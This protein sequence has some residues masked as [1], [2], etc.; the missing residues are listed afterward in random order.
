[1]VFC[2][3]KIS[4][5]VMKTKL[6]LQNIEN[7]KPI[8]LTTGLQA[9]AILLREGLEALLIITALAVYL[10]K[11]NLG[12]RVKALWLGAAA[13]IGV[14]LVAGY[15][16]M[17]FLTHETAEFIEGTVM[18][19]AAAL[20]FYV[21]GWLYLRQNPVV[22]KKFLQDQINKV[23][24]TATMLPLVGIAF[25]AV[26]RE[27][28]ETVLFLNALA[29]SAGGWLS[30][31]FIGL[32]LAAMLLVGASLMA[33]KLSARL[34][35]RP[36]FLF[37]SAFLF[38]IGLQFTIEGIHE[39][40]ELHLIPETYILGNAFTL[41]QALAIGLVLLVTATAIRSMNNAI[42]RLSIWQR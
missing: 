14:S 6:N 18:L 25:L 23:S 12:H 17:T 27:G 26:F 3:F 13:A 36:V 11:A 32:A 29:I 30:S 1:M 24:T 38:I 40:Q 10:K 15:A 8:M 39:L 21:S 34:P 42:L 4:Y 2:T 16:I 31:I 22:W 20:L 9:F 5:V 33:Q 41:E 35:V 7:R 28:A 19:V 37:T